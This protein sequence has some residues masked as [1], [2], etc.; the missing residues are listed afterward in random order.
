MIT[1]IIF[2]ILILILI[3]LSTYNQRV[4]YK[5]FGDP[6][7]PVRICFIAGV[8]GNE[9]AA[10]LHL[11]S[12]LKTD[13]FDRM[14]RLGIF[15]R[16]I[17]C[18]NE[19]GLDMGIRYQNSLFHPDINRTFGEEGENDIISKDMI[20]LT[21][22][23]TLIVDFHE[24]WGFH[25]LDD[26][27]LGSTLSVTNSVRYLGEKIVKRI[28]ETISE[29]FRKFV[30]LDKMCKIKETFSCYNNKRGRDYILVETSGQ[31]DI[32]DMDIRQYQIQ[33]VIETCLEI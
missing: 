31:N 13:Y 30:L 4:A 5:D 22:D 33:I 3:F 17:P 1:I 25:L 18:I 8:H 20:K 16:V 32:Q 10:S 26:K 9:L 28:N 29:P 23:M 12:L 14:S 24:G 7:S 6:F 27:S 19:F 21:K 11:S 15:I 2:G